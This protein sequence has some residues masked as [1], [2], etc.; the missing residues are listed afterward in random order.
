M[1]DAENYGGKCLFYLQIMYGIVGYD[2]R[3]SP[4]LMIVN[5]TDQI[6][7]SAQQR[8]LL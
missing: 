8:V 7:V 5:V 1:W 3:V 4:F 2:A 6:H